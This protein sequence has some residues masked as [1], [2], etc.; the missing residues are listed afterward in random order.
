MLV[1]YA[2]EVR[3]VR[4]YYYRYTIIMQ[5]SISILIHT[6][7]IPNGQVLSHTKQPQPQSQPHDA[8]TAM[9]EGLRFRRLAQ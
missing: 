6:N 4:S 1:W 2:I 3:V 5:T 8:R 7:I 9:R